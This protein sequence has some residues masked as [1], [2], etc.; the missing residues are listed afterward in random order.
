MTA[1]QWKQ[2]TH[3]GTGS[4]GLLKG[5]RQGEPSGAVAFV[6]EESACCWLGLCL[7]GAA[8]RSKDS[9]D[10][11]CRKGSEVVLCKID[12]LSP[13]LYFKCCIIER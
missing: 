5:Q 8:R 1:V 13:L 4:G 7:P 3:V 10:I 11:R 12:L 9:S 6:A 2:Q